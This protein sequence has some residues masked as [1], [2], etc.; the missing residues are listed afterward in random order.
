[1][2][3]HREVK[4]HDSSR[5]S[6]RVADAFDDR[7]S[8]GPCGRRLTVSFMPIYVSVAVVSTL[9]FVDGVRR[10]AAQWLDA[11]R[12]KTWWLVALAFSGWLCLPAVVVVP[13]YLIGVVPRFSPRLAQGEDR[14]RK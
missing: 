14:F 2:A 11:D 3:H 7:S 13:A 6:R 12:A 4:S 1:M 5:T 9:C 10:S 8:T